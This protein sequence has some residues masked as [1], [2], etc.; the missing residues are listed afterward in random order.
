METDL[1]G[2]RGLDHVQVHRFAHVVNRTHIGT[3]DLM[4]DRM[5]IYRAFVQRCVRIRVRRVS[6]KSSTKTVGLFIGVLSV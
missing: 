6:S 3:G 5:K 2:I 4:L 1:S